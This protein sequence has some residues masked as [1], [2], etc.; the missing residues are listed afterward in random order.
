M[1]HLPDEDVPGW[2]FGQVAPALAWRRAQALFGRRASLLRSGRVAA[3]QLSELR[4]RGLFSPAARPAEGFLRGI[5][6]YSG[7]RLALVLTRAMNRFHAVHGYDPDLLQ[8]RHY[9]EKLFASK[10]LRPFK[11]PESGNKLLTSR[12]IPE[13]LAGRLS[14]PEIVWHSTQP[15]LPPD[16]AVPEGV[17]YLK[18]S[19]GSGMFRRIR[20]PLEAR[21]RE[22]LQRLCRQWLATPYGLAD[23]EWWYGAFTPE[24]LL[25]RAI[26][27]DTD[28]PSFN[29]W[30][31]GGQIA[32]ITIYLKSLDEEGT[33][34][35][36]SLW[37]DPGFAPLAQ[38]HPTRP[39]LKSWTLDEQ[40]RPLILDY[41]R[42]IGRQLSFAR[43]D[44]LVDG[45]GRPWLGEVTFAP[46]NGNARDSERTAQNFALWC[47]AERTPRRFG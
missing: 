22:N 36:S 3:A 32:L 24:V 37:M 12:F 47:E 35:E 29:V 1:T 46:G 7:A 4:R 19:H 42:E 15:V 34:Y 41:A 23:G 18:A 13:S 21:Q 20:Y 28:T 11:V 39:V 25:E 27:E 31:F 30:S 2:P 16:S 33:C 6:F 8:P 17:Y 43:I 44:F 26:G 45:E 38:Q 10:F 40:T 5:D 14:C 9:A